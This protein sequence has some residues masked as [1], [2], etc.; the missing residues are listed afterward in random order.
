MTEAL[1]ATGRPELAPV[2]NDGGGEHDAGGRSL[3]L[4]RF[5]AVRI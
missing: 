4:Q 3:A 1:P 5:A 2:H